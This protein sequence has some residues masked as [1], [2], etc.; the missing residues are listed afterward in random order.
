[1]MNAYFVSIEGGSTPVTPPEPQPGDETSETG[2]NGNFESWTGSQP[3]NWDTAAEGTGAG[4]ATLEQSTDAHSG[5]NAVKVQ[6]STAGN[7]RL[8]YKPLQLAAGTYVVKFYAKALADGGSLRSGFVP[9]AGG[10]ADSGKYSYMTGYFDNVPTTEWIL[11]EANLTIGAAGT[12]CFVVMNQKKSPAV[13]ILIDDFTVT[14]DG[15]VIIQ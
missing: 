8:A 15:A 5:N 12:Y 4:N 3:D 7:R 1:V 14:K 10:K 6:G 13:D 11:C 9:V 2:T